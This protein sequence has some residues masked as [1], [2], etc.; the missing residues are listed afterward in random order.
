LRW[1][2]ALFGYR[3]KFSTRG[4]FIRIGAIAPQSML[5]A[6][7]SEDVFDWGDDSSAQYFLMVEYRHL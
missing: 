3:I 5:K 4:S 7:V 1:S 2:D 6:L